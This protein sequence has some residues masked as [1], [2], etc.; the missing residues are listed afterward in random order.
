MAAVG[1]QLTCL[2]A[3]WEN[4]GEVAGRSAALLDEVAAELL[5]ALRFAADAQHP[6]LTASTQHAR[7]A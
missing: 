2:S 4:D 7:C 1:V 3:A 6:I 5:R